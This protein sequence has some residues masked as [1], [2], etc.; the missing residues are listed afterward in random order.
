MTRK[1]AVCGNIANDD[2]DKIAIVK[3]KIEGCGGSMHVLEGTDSAVNPS[4]YN[5]QKIAP[6]DVIEAHGYGYA[7]CVGNVVKYVLR[8]DKKNKVQDLLKALWYLLRLIGFNTTTC[9]EITEYVQV[10]M[11]DKERMR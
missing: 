10:V 8:A 4:H 1:C 11:A 6:I 3:C 2:F 9:Q 7:F 5:D